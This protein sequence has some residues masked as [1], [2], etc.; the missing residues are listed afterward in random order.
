MNLLFAIQAPGILSDNIVQHQVYLL[1]DVID[2]HQLYHLMLLFSQHQ[3]YVKQS[4]S[5]QCGDSHIGGGAV[6]ASFV[7]SL[8]RRGREMGRE[9]KKR[10]EA[11]EGR[12]C[13]SIKDQHRCLILNFK[14]H[15]H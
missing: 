15:L 9:P 3:M 14:M 6:P 1:S 5:V 12:N 4:I 11:L 7:C 2:Q 8:T 13:W 10:V